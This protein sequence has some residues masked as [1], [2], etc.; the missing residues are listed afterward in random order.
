MEKK[1]SWVS[2]SPV[3]IVATKDRSVTPTREPEMVKKTS[4]KDKKEFNNLF[5]KMEESD[6]KTLDTRFE[7]A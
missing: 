1:P 7:A 5:V 6:E 4:E 2:S 3:K